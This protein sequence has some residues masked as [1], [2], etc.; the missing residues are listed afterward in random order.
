MVMQLI[1]KPL[2]DYHT[3]EL[4]G[5][6]CYGVDDQATRLCC[7]SWHLLGPT[8]AE[9][10]GV[11]NDDATPDQMLTLN[12]ELEASAK[13]AGVEQLVALV[14]KAVAS[15]FIEVYGWTY[16]ISPDHDAVNVW[17][18]KRLVE[19]WGAGEVG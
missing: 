17:I 5:M 11:T 8:K 16:S 3:G 6:H 19:P 2:T 13:A 15:H 18:H 9:V 4:V 10:Y 7:A 14:S 12:Q 1:S